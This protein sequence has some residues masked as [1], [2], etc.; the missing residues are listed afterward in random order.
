MSLLGGIRLSSI[1]LWHPP[2]PP[3]DP[4]AAGRCCSGPSA[5]EQSSPHR[6]TTV[7]YSLNSPS[8]P[9][10][11]QTLSTLAA[12]SGDTGGSGCPMKILL[13]VGPAPRGCD[14]TPSRGSDK[15]AKNHRAQSGDVQPRQAEGSP[16]GSQ[17]AFDLSLISSHAQSA[18]M[19]AASSASFHSTEV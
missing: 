1:D 13:D 19:T 2:A 10:S 11:T 8:V 12:R 14:L 5:A 18:R 15:P 6:S 9:V 3:P 16:E 4:A 17:S 7:T